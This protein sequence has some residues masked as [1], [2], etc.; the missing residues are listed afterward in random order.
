MEVV[1]RSGELRDVIPGQKRQPCCCSHATIKPDNNSDDY[2][3]SAMQTD[4]GHGLTISGLSTYIKNGFR[5]WYMELES[6][7]IRLIQNQNSCAFKF[8][9]PSLDSIHNRRRETHARYSK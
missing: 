2:Q 6:N 4:Q 3:C 1:S 7:A 8:R 9:L 5:W